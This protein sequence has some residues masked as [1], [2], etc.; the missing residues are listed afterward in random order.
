MAGKKKKKVWGCTCYVISYQ[1]IF[2]VNWAL[3]VK[4]NCYF[5]IDWMKIEYIKLGVILS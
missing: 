4:K 3:N 1:S 2:V 5:R